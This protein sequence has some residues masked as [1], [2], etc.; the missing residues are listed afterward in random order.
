MPV[1]A[2]TLDELRE[3]MKSL[4]PLERLENELAKLQVVVNE[5]RSA[6]KQAQSEWASALADGAT[7]AARSAD[8]YRKEAKKALEDAEEDY[9]V[10]E[11]ELRSA[12]KKCL[13]AHAKETAEL[14]LP[15]EK[16]AVE[17]GKL[18]LAEIPKLWEAARRLRM[19]HSEYDKIR[20]MHRELCIHSG[21]KEVPLPPGL[22]PTPGGA[23]MF[24]VR[25][26]PI[27]LMFDERK[28]REE[29]VCMEKVFPLGLPKE[30]KAEKA[31]EAKGEDNE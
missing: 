30:D 26:T 6:L 28:A 4:E 15:I 7:K 10:L 29:Q 2:K 18:F 14:L 12:R 3:G 13:H 11:N 17:V 19:L 5:R 31:N 21:A 25:R 8:K 22:I 1:E 24:P 20:T 16:E 9:A 27:S 23:A